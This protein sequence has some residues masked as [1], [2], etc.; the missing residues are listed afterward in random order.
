MASCAKGSEPVSHAD[1]A[2]GD[3][4]P[5]RAVEEACF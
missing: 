4:S 1:A 3:D 5:T 2:V